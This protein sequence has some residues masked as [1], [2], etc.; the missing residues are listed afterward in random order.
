LTV[1]QT[2]VIFI[3]GA[4]R[5]V[6]LRVLPVFL[7]L[8]ACIPVSSSRQPDASSVTNAPDLAPI[9]ERA[10]VKYGLPSIAAVAVRG[11]RVISASAVGER[12]LGSGV[13]V[14]LQDAYHLGSMSKSFTATVLAVLVEQGKLRWNTTLEEA[15]PDVPK[16]EVFKSVT[17]GQLLIHTGGFSANYTDPKL[18]EGTQDSSLVRQRFLN[19][20]LNLEP[21]YRPGTQ[22]AYS[23]VGYILASLIAE[24][25]G[26]DTWQNL[27]RRWVYEPLE[28]TTCT[29]GT[30]FP[31]L[32]NPHPHTLLGTRVTPRQPIPIHNNP[33]LFDGA[34][35][36]RCS[37]PDLGKYLEAHLEGQRGTS[38]F[39]NATT[40]RDLHRARAN[41]GQGI[42]AAYGWFVFPDGRIWHNGSNTLNYSEM[43][44]F[45]R[46][47]LAV[48][49]AS[50]API[51][52]AEG[53]Q[54]A[55]EEIYEALKR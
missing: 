28:M 44:L 8:V 37:L 22:V 49:V 29:F 20:V 21:Q 16:L 33:P 6:M 7:T 40:V 53:V 2:G 47:D 39:L 9:L 48:G 42:Y 34:D 10:R 52:R 36:V 55:L 24:R 5:T 38:G 18:F 54:E 19:A 17:L 43:A 1:V 35:N 41:G 25:V 46:D 32:T 26:G 23:N 31:A 50:N 45:P 11:G 30:D 12:A 3:S 51:Q 27:V 15:F 14:T 4:Y 13:G